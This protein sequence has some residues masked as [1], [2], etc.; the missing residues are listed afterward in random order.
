VLEVVEDARIPEGVGLLQF[1]AAPIYEA[2]AS[3][4]IASSAPAVEVRLET[5]N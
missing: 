1:N 4:L 2:S 3:A 5:V